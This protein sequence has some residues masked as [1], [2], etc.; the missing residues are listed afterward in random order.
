MSVKQQILGILHS[1]E[2]RRIAFSFRGSGGSV[3]VNHESFS[4]VA[5]A[6]ASDEIDIV[7]NRFS[8]DIAM[9]S[10]RVDR[11]EHFAANT[12]YLGRNPRW[13][14]LFNALIVH[15]AVHAS[16]DLARSS[17]PWVDNEAA[18]YIAQAYYARN[19]GLSRFAYNYGTHPFVAYSIVTNMRAHS[20][21]DVDFFLSALR[22]SLNADPMYHQNMS[23]Q[24]NG[25]G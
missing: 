9:Y 16:L 15:E 14:R 12:L 20:Q 21:S 3:S 17:L 23:G 25:D 8:T 1:N 4:R 2:T 5:R 13:S 24:F 7:E 19:S 22:D 10:S 11:R 6:I 18:G